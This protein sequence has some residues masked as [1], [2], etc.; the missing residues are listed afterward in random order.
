MRT[1]SDEPL[2]EGVP[3]HDAVLV[4]CILISNPNR[5][6]LS[7]SR[8]ELGVCFFRQHVPFASV[9]GEVDSQGDRGCAATAVEGN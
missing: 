3:L 1:A 5:P 4:L 2:M 8:T 6:E 7:F 9:H